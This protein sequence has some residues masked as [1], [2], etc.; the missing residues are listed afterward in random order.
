MNKLKGMNG[1]LLNKL[2]LDRP[3]NQKLIH[4]IISAHALSMADPNVG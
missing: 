4:S 2:F 1:A 3:L